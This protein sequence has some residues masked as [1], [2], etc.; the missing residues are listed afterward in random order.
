[1]KK[2]YTIAATA[3]LVFS[4]S[5]CQSKPKEN[6]AA[7][8]EK[9]AGEIVS[10]K[11]QTDKKVSQDEK[12]EVKKDTT[13]EVK[14]DSSSGEKVDEK[15]SASKNKEE[16]DPKDAKAKADAIAEKSEDKLRVVG[17]TVGICGILEKLGYTNVIGIPTSH[18]SIADDYKEAVE[19]GQPMKPN[20]EI[21]KSIEPDLFISE[22]SL[23]DANKQ[24][25][26]NLGINYE[27]IDLHSYDSV[28]DS[29]RQLGE[30][31][32]KKENG[33]KFIE[34]I[35]KK[36]EEALKLAAGKDSPKVLFLFGTPKSVMV[37]TNTSFLGSLMD[38]L[39]IDN[40]GDV[41]KQ[42]YL[43]LSLEDI[44]AKNPDVILVMSHVDEEQTKQMMHDQFETNPA[45]KELNATKNNKIIYLDN[46]VFSVT[47]NAKIG[48]AIE[49]LAEFVYK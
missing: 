16:I 47:G 6:V 25:L 5:A 4:L 32:D 39:H 18:Y 37:G 23:E 8:N 22:K 2:V 34:E 46:E 10:K 41:G 7:N 17:G 13:S 14:K 40:V 48:E 26:D 45:W 44:V 49:K 20:A 29:I 42:P 24:N 19:I 27:F 12:S 30:K 31:L 36:E 21:I 3:L 1:M 15:S 28:I 9:V 33:E 38:K 35:S 11:A 43:P